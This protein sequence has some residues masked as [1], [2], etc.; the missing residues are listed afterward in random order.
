[1]PVQAIGPGLALRI[2]LL[3]GRQ[4]VEERILERPT[5]VTIG[6]SRKNDIC[7]LTD[8]VP[9]SFTLFETQEDAFGIWL[10]DSMDGRLSFGG[11]EVLSFAQALRS[12]RAK[13]RGELRFIPLGPQARG[14][15]Q[16]GTDL[17]VLFQF[18]S[19][20]PAQARPQL[21]PS[22]RVPFVQKLDVALLVIL[23]ISLSAHLGFAGYVSSLPPPKPPSPEDVPDRFVR[24]IVPQRPKR[25]EPKKDKKAP[26]KTADKKAA[27]RPVPRPRELALPRRDL[28]PDTARRLNDERKTRMRDE[29]SRTGLLKILG[30][31]GEQGGA[32]Q[33]LIGKGA[34]A[35]DQDRAFE[36]ISGVADGTSKLRTVDRARE[37]AGRAASIADLRGGGVKDAGT[38]VVK[39]ERELS[40]V[41]RQERANF[42]GELDQGQVLAEIRK[43]N[44]AIRRCYERGLKRNPALK[45][46][47]TLR[48][49]ITLAGTVSQV[50][51]PEDDIGDPEVAGCITSAVRLWRFPPPSGGP[52]TV[53]VPFVFS[54]SSG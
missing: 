40:G 29:V 30:A 39:G 8:A 53:E 23:L 2:G 3:R 49:V 24:M 19:A 46:K 13:A 48:F 9:R 37:G 47:V 21:P 17:A 36:G 6:Q 45:G 27:Q 54:P 14:K 25:A 28:D 43:R 10:A 50:S 1:M 35:S 38:G 11:D 15:I 42:D 41:A 18:V 31:K 51:L 4:L 12:D 32:I 5:R 26:E 20:P 44:G 33:N 34:P 22:L 16:I 52:A 7:L